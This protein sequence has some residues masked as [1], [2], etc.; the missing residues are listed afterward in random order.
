MYRFVRESA[1]RQFCIDGL[2]TYLIEFIDR[3]GDVNDH[4]RRTN[5][6][7]DAG[8]DL[9]V[10][11]MQTY[12]DAQTAVHLFDDLHQF[13]FAEQA[14]RTD[15]IYV[16]LVE[17]AVTS[18]LRT[19]RTPYR[20]YLET[21]EGKTDLLAVLHHVTCKRNGQVVT[22]TFLRRQCRFLT[23]VLNTEEQFIAFLSVLTHEGGEVLH[24][25]R[26]YLL[27]AV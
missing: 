20:L 15:D 11:D 3:Y 22:Q 12:I 23:A 18:F 7:S 4:L 26:L 19:V 27:E 14:V 2:D 25:R 10:V 1:F 6:F 21:L 17:L 5:D 8:K 13:Q 24:G 16:A 9:T